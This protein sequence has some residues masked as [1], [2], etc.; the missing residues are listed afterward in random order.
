MSVMDYYHVD[1]WEAMS[2]MIVNHG[3]RTN[4]H[5]LSAPGQGKDG[6]VNTVTEAFR[7]Q[8]ADWE[9]YRNFG[10]SDIRAAQNEGI[11][12]KGLFD[13][14]VAKNH[15][16]LLDGTP[17]TTTKRNAQYPEKGVGIL[18]WSE[19][20][21]GGKDVR[22]SIMQSLAERKIGEHCLGDGWSQVCSDNMSRHKGLGDKATPAEANRRCWLYLDDGCVSEMKGG[23]NNGGQCAVSFAQLARQDFKLYPD[24]I[25]IDLTKIPDWK[26]PRGI[27]PSIANW[28]ANRTSL[29]NTLDTERIKQEDYAY[30]SNR[31]WEY[32]SRVYKTCMHLGQECY[33]F[34]FKPM[35][36]GLVGPGPAEEFIQTLK[37]LEKE[38]DYDAIKIDGMNAA[39]PEDS[40][41]RMGLLFMA[42]GALSSG[43]HFTPKS[44]PEIFKYIGRL[45]QFSAE[46]PMVF[47]KTLESAAYI[48][49]K[50]EK[51]LCDP[52]SGYVDFKANYY[53]VATFKQAA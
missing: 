33:D 17:Y 36:Q 21:M 8:C 52:D 1:H 25:P 9:A 46:L 45:T 40:T 13:D 3:S 22:K 39:L 30:S 23:I 15:P 41:Y 19:Y 31:T 5:T 53:K 12:I 28:L 49:K 37:L 20:F 11:D 16:F 43:V 47:A 38:L 14:G 32:F 24:D 35:A 29:L 7:E 6:M 48:N 34:V 51:I 50:T 10:H 44:A 27:D 26:C 4:L 18:N 42:I 2:A